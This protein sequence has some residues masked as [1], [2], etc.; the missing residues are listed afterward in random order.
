MSSHQKAKKKKYQVGK[1]KEKHDRVKYK[2]VKFFVIFTS[3]VV[4]ALRRIGMKFFF[5][6]K[7]FQLKSYR[8]EH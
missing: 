7:Y 8:S 1:G 3:I 6:F 2:L 5:V 4:R